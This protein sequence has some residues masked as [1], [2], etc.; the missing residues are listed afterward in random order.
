MRKVHLQ[1]QERREKNQAHPLQVVLKHQRVEK[2]NPIKYFLV[3]FFRKEYMY[4]YKLRIKKKI[5]YIKQSYLLTIPKHQDTMIFIELLGVLQWV[6]IWDDYNSFTV[7]C[8]LT[9]VTYLNSWI[10]IVSMLL[11]DKKYDTYRNM[12]DKIYKRFK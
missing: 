7:Y 9:T 4:C 5:N 3:C 11:N 6:V 8:L 10:I 1:Q 2:S 12:G